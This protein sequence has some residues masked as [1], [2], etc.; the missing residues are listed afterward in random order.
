VAATLLVPPSITPLLGHTVSHTNSCHNPET[1]SFDFSLLTTKQ[2]CQIFL[3]TT[4]QSV[5]TC[6]KA[7][8]S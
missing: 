6:N 3:P 7:A 8:L 1:I 4:V 5:L 2:K